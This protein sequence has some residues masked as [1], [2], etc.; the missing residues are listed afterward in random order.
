[1]ALAF[2]TETPAQCS[3]GA[4]HAVPAHAEPGQGSG[5]V[6]DVVEIHFAMATPVLIAARGSDPTGLRSAVHQAFAEIRRLEETCSNFDPASDVSR[7]NLSTGGAPV[8][9][10]PTLTELVDAAVWLRVAT[11]GAFTVTVGPLVDLWAAAGRRNAWPS[12]PDLAAARRRSATDPIV[13]PDTIALTVPGMR[14]E[15]G[16]IAKGFA[17]D[18]ALAILRGSGASAA[19]VNLGGSSMAA[20]GDAGTRGSGWPIEVPASIDTTPS[21]LRA[22]ALQDQALSVSGSFGHAVVIDGH[23]VGH[24]IDPRS[25]RALE[26]DAVAVALHSSATTA[27]ALSKAV[28]ILG[29]DHGFAV[30]RRLDG[31][32]LL[33]ERGDSRRCSSSTAH[34]CPLSGAR[35]RASHV[36]RGR[37]QAARDASGSC[38]TGTGLGS[39]PDCR[40][41]TGL[42]SSPDCRAG[43]G[44]HSSPDRRG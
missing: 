43:T 11:D 1:M 32:A 9:V 30:V 10:P 23:R 6:A 12:A 42:Q 37:A 21:R 19:L 8:K 5:E 29:A 36:R 31:E 39:S 4:A 26:H 27:E 35:A 41:G 13:G 22:I 38:V 17:A 3:G 40:A 18:R 20:F 34:L 24:V 33:L 44:L 16:G 2:S 28:L 14:I 7:V 15:L 25:G